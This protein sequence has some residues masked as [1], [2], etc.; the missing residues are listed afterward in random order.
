MTTKTSKIKLNQ[1]KIIPIVNSSRKSFFRVKYGKE[2]LSRIK[3]LIKNKKLD[4]VDRWSI[5]NDLFALC[6]GGRERISS[7]LD[8]SDAYHGEESYLAKVNV[9]NNLEFLIFFVLS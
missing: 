3:L 5:Q 1:Q 4:Y 7:Y 8:F 9:A 2:L 6:V